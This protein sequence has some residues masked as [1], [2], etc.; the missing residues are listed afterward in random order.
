V[1]QAAQRDPARPGIAPFNRHADR[2]D[3][4]FESAAGGALFASEVRCFRRLTRHLPRPWLEVGVG[5]GRFARALE[6]DVGVDPA[7]EALRLASGRGVATVAALGQGLPFRG[8][9]FG[10]VFLIATLCFA[11]DPAG[12]LREARRVAADGGVVLGVVPAGSPWA[13]FYA[14]KGRRGHPF[15]SHARFFS[16][17]DLGAMACRAGL[18]LDR[19]SSTLL[20]RPGPR[21]FRVE[22]PRDGV[23]PGAGFVALSYRGSAGR[24]RPQLAQQKGRVR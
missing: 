12:L 10:T 23:V 21:R 20:A 1:A 14:A 2:Y 13:A 3:A 9:A 4:W 22:A 7:F 15:Y 5:T 16:L 17:E 11:N 19:A 8:R 6:I 24:P 18:R